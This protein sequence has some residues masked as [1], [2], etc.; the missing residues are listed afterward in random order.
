MAHLLR[1]FLLRAGTHLF[2]GA[3]E[4]LLAQKQVWVSQLQRRRDTPRLP[5]VQALWQPLLREPHLLDEG[6]RTPVPGNDDFGF[7]H[8]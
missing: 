4:K 5:V 1:L 2:Q 3:E 8:V 6:Q 7:S